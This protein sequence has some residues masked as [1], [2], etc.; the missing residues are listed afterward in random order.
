MFGFFEDDYGDTFNI[1][2]VAAN[3]FVRLSLDNNTPINNAK[4]HMLMFVANG[5]YMV[6]NNEPMLD[7]N[8][9]ATRIGPIILTTY[10]FFSKYGTGPIR[11]P[12]LTWVYG[13]DGMKR[14]VSLSYGIFDSGAGSAIKAVWEKYG[15]VPEEELMSKMLEFKNHPYTYTWQVKSNF[16][17]GDVVIPNNLIDEFFRPMLNYAPTKE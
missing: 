15:Q 8:F 9:L 4:L 12:S 16:G 2:A 13:R 14:I 6:Y 10:N 3:D 7:E 5:W 1:A 17:R 11:R